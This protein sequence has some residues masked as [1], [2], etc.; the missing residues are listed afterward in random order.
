M[1]R[2]QVNAM[3]TKKQAGR[4]LR[5]LARGIGCSA[6][7]LSDVYHGNREPGPMILD[8]LGL[9]KFTKTTVT[10]RRKA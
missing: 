7:Y 5:E 10:Y 3:L 9:E 2:A 6:A 8:Y 1:T 4:S